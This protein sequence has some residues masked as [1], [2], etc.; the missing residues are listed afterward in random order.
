MFTVAFSEEAV[1]DLDIAL[2]YYRNI[3]LALCE[4]FIKHFDE[5][6][7]QL[8]NIPYFQIR[9]DEMR[10]RKIKKFP[11]I[12]HFII[13]SNKTVIVHGVRFAQQNPENYPKI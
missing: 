6:T 4:K 1:E 8:E 5:T 13:N 9:Y 2:E 3:S 10:L 11:V 12:L 7:L